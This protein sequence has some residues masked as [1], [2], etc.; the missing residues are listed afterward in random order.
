MLG[1]EPLHTSGC[2]RDGP[3]QRATSPRGGLTS[4]KGLATQSILL[5]RWHVLPLYYHSLPYTTFV[6]E[7]SKALLASRPNTLAKGCYNMLQH[8]LELSWAMPDKQ[9]GISVRDL[10]AAGRRARRYCLSF[11]SDSRFFG[12]GS[13][14]ALHLSFM[15]W[16]EM[17]RTCR[18]TGLEW[19]WAAQCQCA[20]F[21][22]ITAAKTSPDQTYNPPVIHT[23]IRRACSMGSEERSWKSWILS[24]RPLL[25]LQVL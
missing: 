25:R 22:T 19:I 1:P 4:E 5:C 17:M 23:M 6:L 10:V 8:F 2:V 21:F 12:H 20:C 14:I 13:R 7:F 15:K 9:V 18:R 24:S 11:A 3:W 16:Y